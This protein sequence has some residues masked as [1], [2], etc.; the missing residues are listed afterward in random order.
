MT[1]KRYLDKAYDPNGPIL[2]RDPLKRLDALIRRFGGKPKPETPPGRMVLP[3][4]G[5]RF[6][7]GQLPLFDEPGGGDEP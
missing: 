6:C 3:A 1:G 2:H 7:K 4:V 5:K